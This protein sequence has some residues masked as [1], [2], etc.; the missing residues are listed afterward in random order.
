MKF[1]LWQYLNQFFLD[2][3]HLA[4]VNPTKYWQ[5]YN[6]RHLEK[7]LNNNFLEA[8]WDCNYH[9]FIEHYWHFVD[10]HYLEE[11]DRGYVALCEYCWR[12]DYYRFRRYKSPHHLEE[13]LSLIHSE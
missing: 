13:N 7:C 3:T 1:P 9:E 4:I 2:T 10:R 8:C 12:L 5:I 6:Y 11:G